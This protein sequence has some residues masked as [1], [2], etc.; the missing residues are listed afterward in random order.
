[1]ND[2]LRLLDTSIVVSHFRGIGQASARL[3]KFSGL[4]LPH[5][6]L[7]ELYAGAYRS[8]RPQKNLQQIEQFKAGVTILVPDD[9]TARTFGRIT[10]QLAANG[11]PIPQNDA[12]IAAYALQ[13][14]LTLAT[15]DQHFSHVLGLD[16][17]LW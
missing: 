15:A 12:W 9:E 2:N 1:M 13:W 16:V 10:A 6:A 17:E 4:F 14:G 8:A 11:T 5:T 7:G 3:Q